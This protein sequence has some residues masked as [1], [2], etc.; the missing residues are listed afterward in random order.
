M[1]E[2]LKT[3]ACQPFDKGENPMHG[4]SDHFVKMSRWMHLAFYPISGVSAM[5]EKH[6]KV[7]S[8]VTYDRQIPQ[9]ASTTWLSPH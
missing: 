6:R 4:V 7:F 1:M 2:R 3:K 8:K 5:R 9:V